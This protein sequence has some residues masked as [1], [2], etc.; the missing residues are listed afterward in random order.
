MTLTDVY[1]LYNIARASSLISPEDLLQ[2]V[3]YMPALRLGM[4]QRLF[5]SG[6]TVLQDDTGTGTGM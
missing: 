2:A 5:P 3:S 6:L 4:S 1:C